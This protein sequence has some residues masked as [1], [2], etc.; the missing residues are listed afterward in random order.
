MGCIH[1][2]DHGSSHKHTW[3]CRVGHNRLHWQSWRWWDVQWSFATS[4]RNVGEWVYGGK[5]YETLQKWSKKYEN[6]W[7]A[8]KSHWSRGRIWSLTT[9]TS[10]KGPSWSPNHNYL[11]CFVITPHEWKGIF[12]STPNAACFLC[13]DEQGAI[14]NL[15]S[16]QMK[17]LVTVPKV[18]LSGIHPGKGRPLSTTSLHPSLRLQLHLAG[19]PLVGAISH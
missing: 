6:Q 4:G 9:G 8:V 5:E 19:A 7:R 11:L 1:G 17:Q 13:R 12:D 2:R 15:F 10:R 14:T 3:R 18:I 16:T